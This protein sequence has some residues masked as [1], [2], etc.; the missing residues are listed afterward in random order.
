M[1][2]RRVPHYYLF[3][4]TFLGSFLLLSVEAFV[5]LSSAI[6]RCDSE[7]RTQLLDASVF[8]PQATALCA[9]PNQYTPLPSGLSPFEKSTAQQLDV[10]GSFRK[11][12]AMAM[13]RAMSNQVRLLEIDFPPFIGS[14]KSQFDDYDSLSELN[15]NR[16]WCVQLAPLLK[17]PCTWLVLPD[18]KECELASLA[19]PGQRYR[20]TTKFTSLRAACQCTSSSSASSSSSCC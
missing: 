20:Q 16:D 8:V 1:C 10:Q 18:D 13:A 3:L 19:W 11:I 6:P 4:I 14:G 5:P 17:Q 12:A 9:V 15:A 7:G 2:L